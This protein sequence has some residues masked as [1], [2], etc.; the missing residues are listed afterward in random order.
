MSKY[1]S[2]NEM[3]CKCCGQLPAQGVS[4][5]LLEKL[6]ALRELVGKPIYVTCMYRCISRNA[7][8]G[9]VSNSQHL[10]G[11]GAYIYCDD[12]TVDELADIAIIIG[13]DGVGRYYADEFVHVDCRD[14]GTS[15][16]CYLW[17]G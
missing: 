14:N 1:F 11:T 10:L 7:A 9:G 3:V 12:L 8:V 2:K 4:D 16:A 13:F 5:V 6:D 15:P 17:E